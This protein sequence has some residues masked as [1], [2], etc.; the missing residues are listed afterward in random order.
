MTYRSAARG[1]TRGDRGELIAGNALTAMFIS[2]TIIALLAALLGALA[3]AT[4]IVTAGAANAASCT[5]D[6]DGQFQFANIPTDWDPKKSERG[7]NARY[8][9]GGLRAAGF[10]AAAAAGVLGNVSAESSFDPWLQQ[11]GP[12]GAM[13][14]KPPTSPR[15]CPNV[16]T[17]IIQWGWQGEGSN[18]PGSRRFN[19]LIGWAQ[20]KGK[21]PFNLKTQV[22]WTIK[23]MSQSY[24]GPNGGS[25]AK[26]A[27]TVTDPG[28]AAETIHRIYVSSGDSSAQIAQ[29]RV[30]PARDWYQKLKNVT[31]SS[32]S[33]S[34]ATAAST[35]TVRSTATAAST[36]TVTPAARVAARASSYN[37]PTYY[38]VKPWS[39]GGSSH[40]N[41]VPVGTPVHAVRD[42]VV[43]ESMDIRGYEPRIPV[44][45]GFKSYGRVIKIKY[46]GLPAPMTHAHLSKRFVAA[47]DKVTAGQ[48]VGLSGQTGHAFGPHLHVDFN[49]SY[50]AVSWLT[51][52]ADGYAPKGDIP[53]GDF[54]QISDDGSG[55]TSADAQCNQELTTARTG[56]ALL[57]AYAAEAEKHLGQSSFKKWGGSVDIVDHK[58]L[59]NA[60][61]YWKDLGGGI[62]NGMMP[63]AAIAG[64]NYKGKGL[65]T[66]YNPKVPIPR[67]MVIF[68]GTGVGD[69][70]HVA[71]SD[72][73]GNSVNNWGDNIIVRTKIANQSPSAIIGWGP[74]TV[75]GHAPKA[76]RPAAPGA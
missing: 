70:G 66:P 34:I 40:D 67:G 31:G 16:G 42:G 29:N 6:S 24:S 13:Q 60:E 3:G 50:T 26:W 30:A 23:E 35:A 15:S 63:S 61:T 53:T 39:P 59:E 71:V 68:W 10:S 2:A 1:L 33:A 7:Y 55:D 65:L 76:G 20:K 49:N 58:C 75:F 12:Y 62:E 17:G 46:A 57:E 45:N 52:N 28:Q 22:E 11:G 27:K 64:M 69:A 32:G 36:A 8:I 38:P 4:N 56:D 74:P 18:C 54:D 37:G 72:G 9:F 19:A 25:L 73:R 14:K 47:G 41:S 44:Q 48:I 21:D 5:A 51:G 43:T